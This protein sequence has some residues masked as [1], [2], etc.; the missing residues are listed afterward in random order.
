MKQ[1]IVNY[2]ENHYKNG[3]S[4]YIEDLMDILNFDYSDIYI[5]LEE[6]DEEGFFVEAKERNKVD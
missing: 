4:I 6:L 3:D 1:T 2:I 5:I